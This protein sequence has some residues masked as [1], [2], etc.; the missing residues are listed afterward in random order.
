[1][2]CSGEERQ[3]NF[4]FKIKVGLKPLSEIKWRSEV[5]GK[6]TMITIIINN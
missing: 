6:W 2:T 4:S 1:M 5:S 3:K